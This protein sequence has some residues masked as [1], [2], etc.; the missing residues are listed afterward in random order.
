MCTCVHVCTLMNHLV[1]STL[2]R[3]PLAFHPKVAKHKVGDTER[4][5]IKGE[6]VGHHMGAGQCTGRADLT[7][8]GAAGCH[9]KR[10]GCLK[11][12][13]ECYEA[14]IPCSVLCKCLDCKN[15]PDSEMKSLLQLAD[16][17]GGCGQRVGEIG[18]WG[19]YEIVVY[20]M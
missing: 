8:V 1:Q 13:C 3:N 12:Y 4:K 9:C 7:G 10:S 14:K 2:E 15:R 6:G 17:A 5:H 11:N 20:N 16:A 19:G 18:R